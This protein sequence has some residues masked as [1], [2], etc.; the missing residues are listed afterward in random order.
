MKVDSEPVYQTFIGPLTKQQHFIYVAVGIIACN[1]GWGVVQERVGATKYCDANGEHCERFTSIPVMNVLQAAIAG[2][3]AYAVAY[4]DEKTR[5]VA[6][7]ATFYDFFETSLCHTIASPVGYAAMVFIPYPLY[8]LVSSCKLIPVMAVGMLVN[9]D[10]RPMSDYLSAATMTQGVLLYSANQISGGDGGGHGGGHGKHHGPSEGA[11]T[12]LGFPLTDAMKLMIGI[13]FTLINLSMEGYTNASQDRLFKR[14]EKLGKPRIPGVVMNAY[15]NLWTV[16]LLSVFM[17]VQMVYALVMSP[18]DPASSSFLLSALS[19]AQ[20][21]PEVILHISSFAILGSLAQIFIFTAIEVHGSFRT[22]VCTISRKFVSVLISVALFKHQL[23]FVQW[24]GVLDVFAG[25]GIQLASGG[26][27]HGHHA[28]AVSAPA[29]ASIKDA[30][31]ASESKSSR[32][33]SRSGGGARK[34]I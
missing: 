10:A 32:G 26:G 17:G 22:T 21:H 12:L 33:R 24:I 3:V 4:F 8:V 2:V 19:F 6:H 28:P 23:S 1:L 13:S 20:R 30:P 14:G 11:S 25:L 9:R 16:V 15:M 18:N 5:K 7:G 27:G 34:R 31:V 29:P